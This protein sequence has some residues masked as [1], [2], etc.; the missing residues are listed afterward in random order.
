MIIRSHITLDRQG[1]LILIQENLH[2]DIIWLL[3]IA[4]EDKL[5]VGCH[6]SNLI[7]KPHLGNILWVLDKRTITIQVE[8][9]GKRS[10]H[11]IMTISQRSTRMLESDATV[12]LL[13][14]ISQEIALRIRL[15]GTSIRRISV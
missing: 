12:S 15:F 11:R 3:L 14:D 6:R 13:D 1:S 5:Q 7:I 4:I 2:Q 9:T 8:Q 10:H